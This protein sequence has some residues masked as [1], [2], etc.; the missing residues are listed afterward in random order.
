MT[1]KS[2]GLYFFLQ[3]GIPIVSRPGA[4]LQAIAVVMVDEVVS[5]VGLPHFILMECIA[6]PCNVSIAAD[7]ENILPPYNSPCPGSG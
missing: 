4:R 3:T 5:F 2:N 6:F 7:R 1:W